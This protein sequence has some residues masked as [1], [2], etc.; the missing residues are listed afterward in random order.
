[1]QRYILDY[2]DDLGVSFMAKL[3]NAANLINGL[4]QSGATV[5]LATDLGGTGSTTTQL[6]DGQTLI[7]SA[8]QK[9]LV[10][11]GYA[12]GS[13]ALVNDT[14]Y[15]TKSQI[16]AMFAALGSGGGPS[17]AWANITG[18]PQVAQL[19]YLNTPQ[20]VWYDNGPTVNAVAQTQYVI[21][22]GGSYEIPSSANIVA[23]IVSA[24]ANIVTAPDASSTPVKLTVSATQTSPTMQVAWFGG[25][26]TTIPIGGLTSYDHQSMANCS[27]IPVDTA[28]HSF[29]YQ[30]SANFGGNASL[31]IVGYIF[32]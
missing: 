8:A 5:A 14:R 6:A 24:T 13:T 19:A 20:V 12:A 9:R 22:T 4:N 28:S 3:S 17:I 11:S 21:P 29:W 26:T 25:F 23:V 2:D 7:Y 27:V 32:H 1:M 16:D 30:L 10:S 18:A 15:Y 31:T